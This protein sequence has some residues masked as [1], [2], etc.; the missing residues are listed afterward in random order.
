MTPSKWHAIDRR[1]QRRIMTEIP[2]FV[3]RCGEA[4][5]EAACLVRLNRKRTCGSYHVRPYA[6]VEDHDCETR[7]A[8]VRLRSTAALARSH[9]AGCSR[10]VRQDQ[11]GRALGAHRSPLRRLLESILEAAVRL[12]PSARAHQLR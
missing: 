3:E 11:P 1:Y 12:A 5:T 7:I 8:D 4:C 9:R 2:L 6:D 10:V